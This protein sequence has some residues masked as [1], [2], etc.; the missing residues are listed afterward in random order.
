MYTVVTVTDAFSLCGY[1]RT[2]RVRIACRPATMMSRLMTMARTGRRMNRSVNF[3]G[4]LF[5]GL[6]D[7]LNGRVFRLSTATA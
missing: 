7:V 3:M 4:Q 2:L 6:G 1:W 5:P